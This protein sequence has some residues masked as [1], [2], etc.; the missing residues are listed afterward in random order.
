MGEHVHGENRRDGLHSWDIY[1]RAN[2]DDRQDA[3]GE[4]RLTLNGHS[5]LCLIESLDRAA[6]GVLQGVLHHAQIDARVRSRDPFDDQRRRRADIELLVVLVP[7][8]GIDRRIGINV[9]DEN[10]SL[11][12][13]DDAT[14]VELNYGRV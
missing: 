11:I 1:E 7:D 4:C 13:R 9:A 3:R 6:I 8:V 2:G 10:Q 5:D 12:F 14:T